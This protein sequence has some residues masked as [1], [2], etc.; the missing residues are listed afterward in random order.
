MLPLTGR[1]D[2]LPGEP[3]TELRQKPRH[4]LQAP[5]A[6]A[7][8]APDQGRPGI[9]DLAI[10]SRL[11]ALLAEIWR[12]AAHPTS[13]DPVEQVLPPTLTRM[14]AAATRR[15]SAIPRNHLCHVALPQPVSSLLAGYRLAMSKTPSP[16]HMIGLALSLAVTVFVIDDV[17]FPCSPRGTAKESNFCQVAEAGN[18]LDPALDADLPDPPTAARPEASVFDP[19]RFD[20]HGV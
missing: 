9:F 18:G 8:A 14:F 19:G 5:R 16:V 13:A 15:A 3:A 7:R 11:E 20:F 1:P 12:L 10:S 2:L 17:E 6:F 4:Y